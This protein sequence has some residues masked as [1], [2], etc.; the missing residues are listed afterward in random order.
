[1]SN[2]LGAHVPVGELS[3]AKV[4]RPYPT[5]LAYVVN[6]I[7]PGLWVLR[8]DGHRPGHA[9][10][11]FVLAENDFPGKRPV[12]YVIPVLWAVVGYAVGGVPDVLV[13]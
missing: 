12:G 9:A 2:V 1:M 5:C 8:V 3:M 6:F 7:N 11:D 10:H 4:A 13:A